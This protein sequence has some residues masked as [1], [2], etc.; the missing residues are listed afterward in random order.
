MSVRVT[1]WPVTS[2][3]RIVGLARR[4]NQL[5]GSLSGGE[6]PQ[7]SCAELRS[8]LDVDGRFLG[9]G[10]ARVTEAGLA[11]REA[12]KPWGP[13]ALDTTYAAKSAAALL[14]YLQASN[15]PTLYWATKSSV[16][17]PQVTASELERA[18]ARVHAWLVGTCYAG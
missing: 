8:R 4:T 3:W 12:L 5:L 17:L 6:V 7:V 2:R 15:A 11:A 14:T 13:R 9:R 10:Y 16:P 18:P 1:P